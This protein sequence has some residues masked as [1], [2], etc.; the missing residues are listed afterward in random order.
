MTTSTSNDVSPLP[1]PVQNTKPTK[2]SD[3]KRG[4]LI[5]SSVSHLLNHLQTSDNQRTTPTHKSRSSYSNSKS[6]TSTTTTHVRLITIGASHYCEK[7]RWALDLAEEDPNC[8]FYYTEDAHPP[9]FAA[10]MSVPATHGTSSSVPVAVISHT[11]EY[12]GDSTQIMKRF[13]PQLYGSSSQFKSKSKKNEIEEFEEYL[14]EHLGP[15]IRVLVYHQLLSPSYYDVACKL[16]TH[17]TS[18]VESMLFAKV[19]KNGGLA[20]GM[21]K[22]M[23]VNEKSAQRSLDEIRDVFRKVSD[24]LENKKFLFENEKNGVGF[25]AAD[26]TFAALSAPILMPP[27]MKS[28]IRI[29]DNEIPPA[30]KSIRDELRTTAAGMHV[31]NMYSH[32]RPCTQV[33]GDKES[34]YVIMKSIGRNRALWR[35]SGAVGTVSIAVVAGAYGS[36]SKL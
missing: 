27:Q 22:L 34:S 16:L 18:R 7:A 23:N 5:A 19:L 4:S 3:L 32:Y 8:E 31:M 10:F 14:D 17:N 26:L 1:L 28:I 12:I 24:N 25:T 30:L 2:P 35:I 11:N 20:R 36:L 9:A 21:R 33:I 6:S 13:R 15:S 29:N